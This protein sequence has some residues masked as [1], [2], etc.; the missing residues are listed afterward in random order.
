MQSD[1]KAMHMLLPSHSHTVWAKIAFCAPAAKDLD[2]LPKRDSNVFE[3]SVKRSI[4]WVI[5]QGASWTA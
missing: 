2:Q 3:C 4:C 5:M 1:G